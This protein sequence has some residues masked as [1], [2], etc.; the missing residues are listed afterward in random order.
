M[1]GF[2]SDRVGWAYLLA[3]LGA[4]EFVAA[5]A[6]WSTATTLGRMNGFALLYGALGGQVNAYP[7]AARDLSS[8]NVSNAAVVVSFCFAMRGE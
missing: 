1:T 3:F 6:C 7:A 2:A 5:L 8:N 4:G